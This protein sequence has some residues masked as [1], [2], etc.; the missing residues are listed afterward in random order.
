MTLENCFSIFFFVQNN[1]HIY[2]YI[3]T[4][5]MNQTHITAI[6]NLDKHYNKFERVVSYNMV[7]VTS[8]IGM[9]A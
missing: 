6:L 8:M 9:F 3:Y 5:I 4:F 1:I 2:M 7:C